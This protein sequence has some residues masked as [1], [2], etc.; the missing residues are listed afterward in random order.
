V[1]FGIMRGLVEGER[2]VDILNNGWLVEF[3]Y[4]E[5]FN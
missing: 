1:L 5:G 4:N 2:E 3:V